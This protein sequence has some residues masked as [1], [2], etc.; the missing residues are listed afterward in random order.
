ML[1]PTIKKVPIKEIPEVIEF[2]NAKDALDEFKEE[3]ADLFQQFSELVDKYNTSLENAEKVVRG[4][5]VACGPFDLYQYST[6]YD[7]LALYNAVGRDKFLEMGGKTGTE[8]VYSLDKGR[9][10]AL[11]AQNKV[12]KATLDTVRT[13][14]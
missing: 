10:E 6:K 13:Q 1:K 8:T 14:T 2:V 7:A 4:K 12:P 5:E 3:H 9:F 11:V